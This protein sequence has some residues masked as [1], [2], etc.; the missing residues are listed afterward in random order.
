MG[1]INMHVQH[2]YFGC[3]NNDMIMDASLHFH[4]LGKV[5]MISSNNSDVA[6]ACDND[7]KGTKVWEGDLSK[8]HNNDVKCEQLALSL[9]WHVSMSFYMDRVESLALY[10]QS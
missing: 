7:P 10:I 5:T 3:K 1:D 6:M 4:M 2:F 8:S 9:H